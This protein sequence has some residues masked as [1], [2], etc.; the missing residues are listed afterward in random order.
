MDQSTC[1]SLL[2][3]D[4]EY[5][6]EDDFYSTDDGMYSFGDMSIDH[7]NFNLESVTFENGDNNNSCS[8]QASSPDPKG[9]LSLLN[10]IGRGSKQTNTPIPLR[11]I[12]LRDMGGS[13]GT[14]ADDDDD[15]SLSD[16]LS[17]AIREVDNLAESQQQLQ[18]LTLDTTQVVD[19]QMAFCMGF[20]M[21]F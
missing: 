11:S 17:D 6:D 1:V 12:E 15:F 8:K 2:I 16:K 21:A 9:G 5:E 10:L 20:S 13:G 7:T 14:A 18:Q 19:D 3:T 4:S